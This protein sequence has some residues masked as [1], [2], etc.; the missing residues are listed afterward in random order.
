MIMT[1]NKFKTESNLVICLHASASSAR[2][3]QGLAGQLAGEIEV[4]SPQLTGYGEAV[5]F[6]ETAPFG[7]STEIDAVVEQIGERWFDTETRIHLVGHSYGAATAMHFAH[8]YPERVGSLTLFEP[9]MFQLL[10]DDEHWYQ[11]C[12]EISLLGNYVRSKVGRRFGRK[13]AARRFI[14]YWSGKGVWQLLPAE[15]RERFARMMPKVAA[16]FEAIKSSQVQ[17]RDLESLE[18]PVRLLYGTATRAP[19]RA[20]SEVLAAALPNAELIALDNAEHMA[21]VTAP[22]RVNPLIGEH[23]ERYLPARLRAAA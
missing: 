3:W 22:D 8:R 2:Q 17:R 19:A 9:V 10:A 12:R 6:D 11:E 16:E 7:F 5:P 14:E 13:K 1:R 4:L 18:M 23:L 20:V 21:P 15:R